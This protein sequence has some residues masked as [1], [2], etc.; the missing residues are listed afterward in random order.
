MK[1]MNLKKM[2]TMAIATMMAISTMSI[3]V[4]AKE[5]ITYDS[6]VKM[7]IYETKE[8]FDRVMPR[9]VNMTFSTTLTS[10]LQYL[11]S[12][13]TASE[14]MTLSGDETELVV[15]FDESPRSMLY[16]T[17]YDVTS[18]TYLINN[19]GPYYQNYAVTYSDLPKTHKFK[20]GYR[21]A[22]G[23]CSISGTVNS[24]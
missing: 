8:E 15:I 11:R 6:G 20:L 21:T 1:K 17:L 16:T 12:L 10:S 19:S 18:G 2:L 24:Y 22:S 7:T 14:I 9:T 4:M 13:Q 3:S 23:T 5:V